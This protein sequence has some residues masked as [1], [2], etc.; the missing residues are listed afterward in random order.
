MADSSKKTLSTTGQAVP[1]ISTQTAF[2][3][4]WLATPEAAP[5]LAS[6]AGLAIATHVVLDPI[7]AAESAYRRRS[8]EQHASAGAVPDYRSWQG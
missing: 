2:G 6:A 3:L 7:S 4:L 1:F 5:A 8:V